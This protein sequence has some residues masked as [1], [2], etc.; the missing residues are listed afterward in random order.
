MAPTP[1]PSRPALELLCGFRRNGWVRGAPG[2]GVAGGMGVNGRPE[3]P[4][5]LSPLRS[6]GCRTPAC[7]PLRT[8][9]SA[10]QG[11][12]PSIARFYPSLTF[13]LALTVCQALGFLCCHSQSKQAHDVSTIAFYSST[14]EKTESQSKKGGV[15]KGH[16]KGGAGIQAQPPFP[17]LSAT[18]IDHFLR[19]AFRFEE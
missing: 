9:L 3:D 18:E 6:P 2:F 17:A 5:A 12:C 11:P 8:N 15:S 4:R 16:R 1:F 7:L 10:C 14:F 19:A 13:V